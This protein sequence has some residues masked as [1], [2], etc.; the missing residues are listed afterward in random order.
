MLKS[1]DLRGQARQL[2]N[3]RLKLLLLVGDRPADSGE[4][5][6]ELLLGRKET[7]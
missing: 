5:F 1:L 2:V 4:V 6:F 7:R 3:D